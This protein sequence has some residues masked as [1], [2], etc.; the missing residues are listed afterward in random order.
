MNEQFYL[1]IL[2]GKKGEYDAL[3]KLTSSIKKSIIPLIEIPAISWDFVKGAPSNSLEKQVTSAIKSI[4]KSWEKDLPILIDTFY[5][6]DDYNQH[7]TTLGFIVNKLKTDGYSPIPVFGPYSTTKI[8]EQNKDNIKFCIRVTI[9]E[10][11]QFNLNEEIERIIK[12]LDTDKSKVILL[13][14]L[15]YIDEKQHS[16]AKRKSL[17]LYAEVNN[18]E[19][20]QELY[21]SATSFPINL[22]S[23]KTNSVTE[24]G[25]IEIE[26]HKA[27]NNSKEKL[28]RI[29][30]FSDYCT[31]NPE[32]DEIDPRFMT[33]SASIRYTN[34]NKWYIFKGGSIKK[35]SS[36][37]FYTLSKD[38]IDSPIYSGEKFS[39]GDKQIFDKSKRISG[40]GNPTIWRQISVNH[41]ITLMV[42]LL[43]S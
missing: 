41:H 19:E 9:D 20:F 7:D 24:I 39:W 37:Q 13:L 25:R 28:S 18:I 38:V 40:P 23:C 8:I 6:E 21:F 10:L 16:L 4:E 5:L 42:D 36:D 26:I 34:N 31:S 3:N 11:E 14:D 17:D 43:S 27:F 32:T 1:P 29:P 12:T 22:S 15:G 30:K 2:K 33:V 35:Y